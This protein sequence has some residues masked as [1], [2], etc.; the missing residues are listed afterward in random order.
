M[1]RVIDNVYSVG[2]KDWQCRSFHGYLTPKGVT[3]NSYLIMDEKICLVDLVKYTFVD[4]FLHNISKIVD[5]SKI[6]YIIINHVENDHTSSLPDIMKAIPGA[7]VYISEKGAEEAGKLY[8]KYDYNVVKDGDTLSIGKK[9]VRFVGLPMLHWPD[10]MATYLVEDGLLFSND[11]FGQHICTSHVFDDES[12]LPHVYEELQHYY[13]NILMPYS[14][15]IGPALKKA[16]ALDLKMIC[17]SHGVI[18]RSHIAD[19]LSKYEAWGKGECKDKVLVIYDTMWGATERMARAV[20]EGVCQSGVEA[21]LYKLGTTEKSQL[22]A[23]ILDS[24]GMLLG[25]PTLNYGMFPSFGEIL[26]Y[27]KGLK[28]IDK[29]A[30]VFG[31]YGWSGGAQKDMEELLGKAGIEVSEGYTIKWTADKEEI[32]NC[33]KLGYEFA[34]KVCGK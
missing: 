1:D 5:P 3:Y 7:K 19:M 8:G 9:T 2:C 34:K 12:E 23:D 4:E 10:S 31:A 21:K 24:K 30:A 11:A 20:F 13:A 17:P 16:G 18:W 6:D 25:S 15:L 28:P 29:K 22:V 32:A 14:R 27:L 33:E 26:Y